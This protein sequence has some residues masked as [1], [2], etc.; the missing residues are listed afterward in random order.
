V[1]L[2]IAQRMLAESPIA[3]RARASARR[4]PL[5][6]GSCDAVV[7]IEVIEHLPDLDAV[8]EEVA[9]VLRPGGRLVLVDK[10]AGSLD[11]VR[12]Y[13]PGLLVK[14]IDER[15]GRWMYPAEGPFRERWFWPLSVRRLLRGGFQQRRL[16]YLLSPSEAAW[17]V[18]RTWPRFRR[19][20]LW[21]AVRRGAGA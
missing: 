9:R 8:I 12:P 16:E 4:L 20:V 7:G 18:F 11:P 19:F 13:L 1:G 15:R 14:L 21:T 6:D 10:N 17:R 2:D 3:L 5:A